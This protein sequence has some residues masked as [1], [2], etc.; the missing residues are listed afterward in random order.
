MT[1]HFENAT[2]SLGLW[3]PPPDAERTACC[4]LVVSLTVAKTSFMNVNRQSKLSPLLKSLM[5][6]TAC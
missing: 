6:T 3:R 5:A 4:V 1:V 2:S